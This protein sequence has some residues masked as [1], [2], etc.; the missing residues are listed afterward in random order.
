MRFP[1]KYQ[2]FFTLAF[3]GICL[4]FSYPE[5]YH[6]PPQSTHVWRQTDGAGI[7]LNYHFAKMEFLRPQI[8]NVCNDDGY[9]VSEFPIL[10]YLSAVYY[11][12]FGVEEGVL[13]ILS[14]VFVFWGLLSL[15]RLSYL[16]IKEATMAICLPLLVF[17]SP[18]LAYYSFNFLPDPAAL[19]L[20]FCAWYYYYQWRKHDQIR[21]LSL[22]LFTTLLAGLLKVISLISLI[23]LLIIWLIQKF[24]IAAFNAKTSFT[25]SKSYGHFI[26]LSFPLLLVGGWLYWTH[27]YNS[28]HSGYFFAGILPLWSLVSEAQTLIFKKLVTKWSWVYFHPM[29]HG[30]VGVAFIYFLGKRKAQNPILWWGMGLLFLANVAVYLLWFKQFNHHDYY[31]ISLFVFPVLVLLNLGYE[32]Q[33]KQP[34]LLQHWVFK[35]SLIGFTCFHIFYAKQEL[36][37]RY[38]V[39]S[40]YKAGINPNFYETAALQD[41]LQRKQIRYEDKVLSLPDVSPNISL[42]YYRLRGWTNYNV[43]ESWVPYADRRTY[44]AKSIRYLIQEKDCRYLLIN[45]RSYAERPEFKDFLDYPLGDFKNSIFLFDLRPYR[46]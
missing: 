27:Q 14:L 18:L 44:T 23:A 21:Y 16:L 19:G 30:V 43:K 36:I 8:M 11:R 10:Y 28:Q 3:L 31:A 38:K 6:Y 45:Q 34:Q 24:R 7:A 42:Y 41:W 37:F 2:I 32:L 9:T 17:S 22:F 4:Y 13:R 5:I 25:I 40:N 33:R 35:L 46:E 20:T 26:C 29:I 15:H 39:D 1:Q 12:L